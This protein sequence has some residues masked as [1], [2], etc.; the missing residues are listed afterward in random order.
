MP[1]G[2]E[3]RHATGFAASLKKEGQHRRH[4]YNS[5][6]HFTLFKDGRYCAFYSRFMQV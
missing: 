2:K 3:T 1:T 4:L 5:L 6:R